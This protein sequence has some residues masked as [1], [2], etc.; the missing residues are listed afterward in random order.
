MHTVDN[1]IYEAPLCGLVAEEP[2][3]VVGFH[4]TDISQDDARMKSSKVVRFS[5][6]KKQRH[7]LYTVRALVTNLYVAE[8][9]ICYQYFHPSKQSYH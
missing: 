5:H 3:H 7:V 8:C 2:R 1:R 6:Q 4:R 9:S